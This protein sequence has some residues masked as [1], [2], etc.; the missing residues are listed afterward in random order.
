MGTTFHTVV[1]FGAVSSALMYKLSLF[2]FVQHGFEK[3][4]VK[5]VFCRFIA[6]SKQPNASGARDD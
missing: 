6:V 1:C 2:S 4:L 5:T 3:S